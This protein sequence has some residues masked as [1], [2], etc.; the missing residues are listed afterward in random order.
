MAEMVMIRTRKL[1]MCQLG[2]P[3]WSFGTRTDKRWKKNAVLQGSIR[4]RT[5][6][7]WAGQEGSP[8]TLTAALKHT[9]VNKC[10]RLNRFCNAFGSAY[11]YT[12]ILF[13][14]CLSVICLFL[15]QSCTLLKA[16]SGFRCTIWLVHL[17]GL[18]S[19][20]LRWGFWPSGVEDIWGQ[21]S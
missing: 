16:F 10:E 4:Y 15:A 2:V 1:R 13:V 7:G 14:V 11:C 17:W 21:M 6:A 5:K 18:M 8:K 3:G 9:T 19:H 20:C 12:F